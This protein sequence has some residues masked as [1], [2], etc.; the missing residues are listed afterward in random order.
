MGRM[1]LHSIDTGGLRLTRRLTELLYWL[2]DLRLAEFVAHLAVG[3][4]A[5]RG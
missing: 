5:D 3:L 1:H 4:A 2:G